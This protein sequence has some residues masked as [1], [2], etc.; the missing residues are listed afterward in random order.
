VLASRQGQTAQTGAIVAAVIGV[1]SSGALFFFGAW[2][3]GG[4]FRGAVSR[5]AAEAEG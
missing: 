2:V 1:V 3:P 5:T 4:V